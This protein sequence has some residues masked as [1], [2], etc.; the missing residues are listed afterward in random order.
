MANFPEK[1]TAM[2]DWGQTLPIPS[3]GLMRPYST[4]YMTNR[5]YAK[6]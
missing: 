3:C 1:E 4:S 5:S 2:K 6:A